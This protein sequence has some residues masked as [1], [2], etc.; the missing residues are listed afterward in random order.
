MTGPEAFEQLIA[1]IEAHLTAPVHQTPAP[2]GSITFTSGD[3]IEVHVRLSSSRVTVFEHQVV[4]ENSTAPTARPRQVGSANW[5]RLPEHTVMAVVGGLI[6]GA[7]E[8]RL[9]AFRSCHA[10]GQATPPEWLHDDETCQ[11]CYERDF[12][13][14]VH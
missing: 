13:G 14:V 2:D 9:Q 7:R 4:W 12:G 1:Y 5:R 8:R 6:K 10:C 3:P 11:S